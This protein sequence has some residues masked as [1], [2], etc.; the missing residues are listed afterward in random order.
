M[1]AVGI[2]IFPRDGSVEHFVERFLLKN[3]PCLFDAS[4]TAQW[5][6]RELWVD[7]S[8][9]PDLDYLCRQYGVSCQAY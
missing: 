9:R 2:E 4:F 7:A 8:G 6:C 1:S 3:V 5:R